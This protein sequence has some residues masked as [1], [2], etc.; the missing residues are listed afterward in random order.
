MPR[1]GRVFPVRWLLAGCTVLL[2]IAGG[3]GCD[4]LPDRQG[5]DAQVLDDLQVRADG[6]DAGGAGKDL[7]A[8]DGGAVADGGSSDGSSAGKCISNGSGGATQDLSAQS[9]TASNGLKSSY[10][11]YAANLDWSKPVG[12][13][14]ILHGDGGGFYDNPSW[15]ANEM[16]KVLR[17]HNMLTINVL[18]PDSSTKTWWKNGGQNDEFLADL[19]DV[20]VLKRYSIDKDRVLIVG[21]SGGGD[22]TTIYYVPNHGENYCGGGALIF[23]GG[24]APWQSLQFSEAFKKSFKLHFY[25]GQDDQFLS[26]AQKGSQKYSDLGFTVTTE[27]PAGIHHTNIPFGQVLQDQLAKGLLSH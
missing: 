10:H 25:T 9:F 11:L 6:M 7:L 23:G 26:N 17:G 27:W 21:Y 18:T 22:F 24:S 1:T 16:I 14:V 13:A 2:S 8:G 19:I 20:E 12:L 4:E 15:G 3:I 5:T